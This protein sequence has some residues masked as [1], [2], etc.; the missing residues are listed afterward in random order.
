MSKWNGMVR[1]IESHSDRFLLHEEYDV[2]NGCIYDESRMSD[3]EVQFNSIEHLNSRLD[4]QF[5]LAEEN[6]TWSGFV[7]CVKAIGR[8]NLYTEGK[9]YR[10]IN[11]I[12]TCDDGVSLEK[13]RSFQD[14][15][16]YSGAKWGKVKKTKTPQQI[17]IEQIEAEQRKLADRLSELRKGL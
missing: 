1:C 7:R 16:F 2:V 3:C 14:L 12:L 8:V 6:I 11:G 4:S 15:C 5:E 13:Y 17:E 9:I 10:I